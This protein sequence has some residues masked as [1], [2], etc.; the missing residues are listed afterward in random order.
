MSIQSS[1]NV[2]I[3]TPFKRGSFKSDGGTYAQ[4][5]TETIAVAKYTVLGMVTAS[6]KLKALESDAVDGSQYPIGI[7]NE[8]ILAASIVAGDVEILDYVVGGDGIV[9]SGSLVFHNGTDT[10]DTM[11]GGK[12]IASYLNDKGLFFKEITDFEEHENA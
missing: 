12:T 11:V 7:I 6:G 5:A 10:L 4:D 2:T 8:E 1:L 3:Q 9:D